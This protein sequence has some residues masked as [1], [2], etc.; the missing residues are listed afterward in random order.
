MKIIFLD[1]NGVLDTSN[2][3]DEIDN[4]NLQILKNIVFKTD[5]KI[6]IS[7]SLKNTFYLKSEHSNTMRKFLQI[8]F[9]CGLEVIGITPY[10]G[11]RESEIQEYLK[12]HPEISEY[13]IIDDDYF[14]ES[15]KEHMIKLNPQLNGGN[16][17]KDIDEN[18]IIKKLTKG[19][20]INE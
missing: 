19:K 15:M 8:L 7:S 12:M 5:A 11:S 3:F 6:V 9:D 1:F 10:M 14:F 17:L 4:E 13:C 18:I 20:N 16:G 2:T